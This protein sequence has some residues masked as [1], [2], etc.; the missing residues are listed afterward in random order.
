MGIFGIGQL[1]KEYAA[2][3]PST[4]IPPNSRILIDGS[5]WCFHLL[6]QHHLSTTHTVSPLSR[7]HNGDYDL[8]AARTQQ[9]IDD[10]QQ[11]GLQPEVWWDGTKTK[12]KAKTH[13]TR[14]KQRKIQMNKHRLFCE[15]GV[16]CSQDDLPP[17]PLFI[18]QVQCTLD[19]LGVPQI[20]CD[21]EAD[22][23]LAQESATALNTFVLA[24]DSDFL[25][26]QGCKYIQ[27]QAGIE[28][29]PST[30]Q[31]AQ[32]LEV[33]SGGSTHSRRLVPYAQI[34]TR[35]GLADHFQSNE[36]ILVEWAMYVGNDF[37]GPLVRT[38]AHGKNKKNNS[39]SSQQL[40]VVFD[41][42][43]LVDPSITDRLPDRDTYQQDPE[44]MLDELF[45]LDLCEEFNL[46]LSSHNAG[47]QTAIDFSRA[48]YN[49]G[50]MRGFEDDRREQ[51]SHEYR[52][53]GGDEE[54]EGENEMNWDE[55]SISFTTYLDRMD[56]RNGKA[57]QNPTMKFGDVLLT[58]M[59][60]TNTRSM[61]RMAI[62][63]ILEGERLFYNNKGGSSSGSSSED[64]GTMVDVHLIWEDVQFSYAYQKACKRLRSRLKSC[65]VDD[66]DDHES[67]TKTHEKERYTQILSH[68]R[69]QPRSL[70]HGPTFHLMVK[71]YRLEEEKQQ[72][73]QQQSLNKQTLLEEEIRTK[74]ASLQ[75]EED[76]EQEKQEEQEQEEDDGLLPIDHHRE[77]ILQH[78]AQHRVTIIQVRFSGVCCR[79]LW[80]V[81]L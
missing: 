7:H 20:H 77:R 69:N 17:P 68:A 22:P 19:Q 60:K 70:F 4:P 53:G 16:T 71:D 29:H 67:E 39:S 41:A 24:N 49:H 13:S 27:L 45:S 36:R 28:S 25:F 51:G 62:Q 63:R 81:Y 59:I 12:L 50:D 32:E 57:S 78:I 46:E 47:L 9:Y 15:E 64:D 79:V 31:Q 11:L 56:V 44:S 40:F 75:L 66:H 34:L 61:H 74:L 6:N 30:V 23:D 65:A 14:L 33:F 76:Q 2:T 10:L 1:I 38:K 18:T 43:H 5:G 42:N 55:T 48:Y 21:Y 58:A 54:E 26:F 72:Q 3:I 52:R 8:L 37:T 35:K 80:C 73:Q